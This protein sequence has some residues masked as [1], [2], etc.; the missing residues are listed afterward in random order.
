[1]DFAYKNVQH[2]LNTSG[3][4]ENGTPEA[5]AQS[6]T[7][8]RKLYLKNYKQKYA[9]DH[10]NVTISFTKKDKTALKIIALAQGKRLASYI[11]EKALQHSNDTADISNIDTIEAIK[12][13]LS[14]CLDIVEELQ[15]ENDYP[16]LNS[17]FNELE[18][19]LNQMCAV[20]DNDY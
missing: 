19:L 11:K 13:L 10:S 2:Y 4:L 6:R 8:F 7:L 9:E 14:F 15:F 20:I 5:I 1:M 12:P 3:V 16:A 18:D 17:T